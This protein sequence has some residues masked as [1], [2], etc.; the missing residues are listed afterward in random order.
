MDTE[1]GIKKDKT[2]NLY[3]ILGLTI[4]VCKDQKCNELIQKAYLKKAKLC[5][6]DKHPGRKDV[7]EVFEL[8]TGAYDILKNEKQRNEYNHKLAMIKESSNDFSKLKKKTEEYMTSLG[9]YVPPTDTQ[10]LSFK[11]QGALMDEK[12]GFDDS[13]TNVPIPKH[14]AKKRYEDMERARSTQDRDLKQ[15]RMFRDTEWNGAKFNKAFERAHKRDDDALANHN[16]VPSAWNCQ[17]AVANFG[18]FDQLDNLYVDD[19]DRVD[20]ERQKFSSINFG[21][22][23]QHSFSIE[24]VS[25]MDGADYFTGHNELGDDYYADIKKRLRDRE[26]SS[27]TYDNMKFDDFQR[28][29][30]AGYGIHDQVGYSC[31]DRLCLDDDTEDDISQRFEALMAQRKTEDL[32]N[33]KRRR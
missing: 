24:E 5:H 22:L 21:N 15:E 31:G 18:A 12:H 6:P 33:D 8:I 3:N 19:G 7:A 30:F 14:E 16:G 17:G 29:D 28:D 27:T 32:L 25:A 23:P 26:S 9:E 13:I 2:L 4:D 11:Q 20:T 1:Y 10:K